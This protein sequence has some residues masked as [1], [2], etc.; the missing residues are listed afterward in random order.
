MSDQKILDKINQEHTEWCGKHWSAS[1]FSRSAHIGRLCKAAG[2]A[3]ETVRISA[4]S[5]FENF[6]VT[7]LEVER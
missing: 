1:S 5:G 2:L 7:A 6:R 4:P 3:R